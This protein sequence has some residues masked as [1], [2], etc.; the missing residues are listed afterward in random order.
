[1]QAGERIEHTAVKTRIEPRPGGH[2]LTPQQHLADEETQAER[3]GER[4][5]AL[6]AVA[7]AIAKRLGGF[8]NEDRRNEE[9]EA[10]E[11]MIANVELWQKP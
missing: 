4:P 3:A 1:M 5:I 2:H 10:W 9:Q 6:K 7:I 11:A 8:V